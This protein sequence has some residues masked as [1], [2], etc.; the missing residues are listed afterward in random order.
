MREPRY[1]VDIQVDEQTSSMFTA[2]RVTN[3]SR[4]GLF[5]ETP[6][7]LPIKSRVDIA[8]QLPEIRTVLHVHGRVVW[9]YDVRRSNS[10]IM[11]GTGIKFEDMSPEQRQ[12]LEWYLLRVAPREMRARPAAAT[13]H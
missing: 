3:I 4:G 5:M 13:A 7:P 9:T 10:Q 6:T 8:L 1:H 12:V 2:G 11:T